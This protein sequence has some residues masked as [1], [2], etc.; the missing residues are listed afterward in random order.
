MI[1]RTK[2]IVVFLSVMLLGNSI[3]GENLTA[4]QAEN[5]L[6]KALKLQETRSYTSVTPIG[7]DK[8]KI[9][10]KVF[11]KL[12]SD[13][14]T[15]RRGESI[16][17]H[18]T[19]LSIENSEGLFYIYGNSNV[20][21][22]LAFKYKYKD[23]DKG[24]KYEIKKG[25]YKKIPC[26]IITQKIPCNEDSFAFFMKNKAK[27]HIERNKD[28]LR[29]WY[30][31]RCV[32]LKIYYIGEKDNFI[33]KKLSYYKNGKLHTETLYDNVNLNPVINDNLFKLPPNC[34]IKIARTPQETIKIE[35]DIAYKIVNN[36]RR[37]LRKKKKRKNEH[38]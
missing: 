18:V 2:S 3:L 37:E 21:V 9:I 24:I 26:Y 5:I 34:K 27:A 33:Y 15:Y 19:V 4:E 36:I 16:G 30:F 6:N 31:K 28:K 13:G 10:S 11:Q 12:N 8:S 32:V 7:K 29:S 38:N 25:Y 22:K 20:A 14:I 1:F 35:R 23:Y 17:L